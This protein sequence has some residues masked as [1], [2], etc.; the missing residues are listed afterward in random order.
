MPRLAQSFRLVLLDSALYCGR[1]ELISE[2]SIVETWTHEWVLDPGCRSWPDGPNFRG[3]S[4]SSRPRMGNR[5]SQTV[6]DGEGRKMSKSL[7]NGVDPLE[8]VESFGA[9]AMRYTLVSAAAIG[10]DMQLDHAD[11]E[12]SFRVG[13]NFANK[14]WNAVRFALG[15]LGEEG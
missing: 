1:F 2:L 14:I 8:V 7:G 3:L 13:R 11:L 9:D 12:G 15:G 10:T 5:S 4:F 6:R